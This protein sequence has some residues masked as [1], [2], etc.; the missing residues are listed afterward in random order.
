MNEMLGL[1]FTLGLGLFILIGATLV[2]IMKNS[3]KLVEFSIGLALGI[4]T[5]LLIF[6]IT[7]EAYEMLQEH[8]HG[9]MIYIVMA[10]SLLLGIVGL[11]LLDLFIPDHEHHEH[12]NHEEKEVK[13][14]LFHIGVVSSIAIIIH[15]IIEGMA[16]YGTVSSSLSMGLLMSLGVG[17]HNIPLGMAITSTVYQN[18]QDKKKTWI[19]ISLIALS[20][21]VGGL[22]MFL[23]SSELLNNLILGCLLSVTSGMLIYIVLFELLPHLLEAKHK[24]YAYLGVITGIVIFILSTFLG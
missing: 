17:L 22:L 5:L 24:K 1:G 15:N 21:F 10:L 20:T 14:N 18:S 8:L 7:P 4:M 12:D 6:E 16:V 13:E 2:F 9:T 19:L 23:F 11:K 3:T